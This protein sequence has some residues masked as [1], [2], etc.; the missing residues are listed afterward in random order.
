MRSRQ[1]C[2]KIKA[3]IYVINHAYL[4]EAAG[5]FVSQ[6]AAMGAKALL[7]KMTT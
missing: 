1:P 2:S 6:I 3:C 7:P 5:E 4:P